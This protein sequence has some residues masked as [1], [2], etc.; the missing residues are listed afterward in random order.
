MTMV[1]WGTESQVRDDHGSL[2]N[3]G[4]VRDDHGSMGNRE[5]G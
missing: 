3:R 2:G 4:L 5:S 1:P